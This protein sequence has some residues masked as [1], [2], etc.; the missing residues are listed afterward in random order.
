MLEATLRTTMP[1]TKH[2]GSSQ[3][4]VFSKYRG[5]AKMDCSQRRQVSSYKIRGDPYICNDSLFSYM[6]SLVS[7]SLEPL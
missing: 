2:A 3:R 7:H 4:W 5:M 6:F 1:R